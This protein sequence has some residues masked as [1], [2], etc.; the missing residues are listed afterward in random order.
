MR[1]SLGF[2]L[3]GIALSAAIA[4]P[5]GPSPLGPAAAQTAGSQK[6]GTPSAR[7]SVPKGAAAKTKDAADS[8]TARSPAETDRLIDSAAKSLAGGNADA[9]MTTLDGVLAGGGLTNG[10]M[11]RA[12]YLRG[13]A[14]RRKGRPAQ[15]IADLTSAIWLK[16]GLNEADRNAALKERGDV[17]REVGVAEGG[18]PETPARAESA[19][20]PESRARPAVVARSE[21]APA[22][23]PAP[24][25]AAP[26]P[27][28]APSSGLVSAP[29][30]PPSGELSEGGFPR[31]SEQP[32][33]VA[34]REVSEAPPAKRPAQSTSSWESGTKVA[35]KDGWV[36]PEEREKSRAASSQPGTPG[37]SGGIGDFLSG[38]F[39][40]NAPSGQAPQKRAAE[41]SDWSTSTRGAAGQKAPSPKAQPKSSSVVTSSAPT[42][43][44]GRFRLQIAAVRSRKEAET[45]AA[46]VKKDHGRVI[47]TRRLEVDETVFGNMGT[48]YRVRL[49]P[50]AAADEPKALCEQLRPSGYD[51]LVVSQ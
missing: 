24:A 33:R 40:G 43:A 6:A 8:K 10:H 9:A 38:L 35:T 37:S 34:K 1:L 49:G 29:P 45:V 11:A 30:P 28:P 27:S 7:K 13:V 17:S 22:A 2:G 14:H 15:A 46:R 18:A 20:A 19:A 4:V 26:R 12:L 32:P 23:T 36:S 42:A 31:A 41:A 16:D 50:F 51:C 21:P 5:L 47:G 39:T 44:D 25:V 48:F 3:A